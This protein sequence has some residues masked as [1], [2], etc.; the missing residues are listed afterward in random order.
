VI[1]IKSTSGRRKKSCVYSV[2][3]HPRQATMP[4]TNR[5]RGGP[6]TRETDATRLLLSDKIFLETAVLTFQGWKVHVTRAYVT[7]GRHVIRHHGRIG[8]GREADL[9]LGTCQLEQ[10]HLI[11]SSVG[12]LPSRQL[13]CPGISTLMI[14][15][16]R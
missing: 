13:P 15:Q 8:S 6:R 12:L 9:H 7:A 16:N 10:E 4:P 11:E 3:T 5:Q 14:N 2:N 1:K